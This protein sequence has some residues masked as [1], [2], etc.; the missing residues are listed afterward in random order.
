MDII[1]AEGRREGEREQCH[2]R[3]REAEGG[4]ERERERNEDTASVSCDWIPSNAREILLWH[5]I[6]GY[7]NVCRIFVDTPGPRGMY[8]TA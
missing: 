3:D 5:S 2:T 4:G 8:R 6:A 7:A 1:K